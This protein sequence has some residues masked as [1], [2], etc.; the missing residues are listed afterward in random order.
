MGISLPASPGLQFLPN[1]RY[2]KFLLKQQSKFATNASFESHVK[3][4]LFIHLN[5]PKN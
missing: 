4:N 1:V 5:G 2:M 3:I